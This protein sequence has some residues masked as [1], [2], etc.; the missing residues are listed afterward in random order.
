[1]KQSKLLIGLV[2]SHGVPVDKVRRVEKS[3]VK[4]VPVSFDSSSEVRPCALHRLEEV[5][6]VEWPQLGRRLG[7]R[8]GE[9]WEERVRERG[10][11]KESE[12]V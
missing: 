4:S 6:C 9:R 3:S 1:M 12:R 11:K 7:G 5:F 2:L 8:G 10:R